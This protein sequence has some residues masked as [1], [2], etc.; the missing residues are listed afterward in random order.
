[1]TDEYVH[2]MNAGEEVMSIKEKEDDDREI[3][4]DRYLQQKIDRQPLL[5]DNWTSAEVPKVELQQLPAGLK[6]AFLYD[7]FSLL[8]MI[9]SAVK[10]LRYY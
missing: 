9:I 2:L 5:L 10:N 3:D 6:Y 4:M 8:L 7:N 1:M